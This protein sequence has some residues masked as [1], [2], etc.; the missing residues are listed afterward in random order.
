MTAQQKLFNRFMELYYPQLLCE[1][2]QR[3]MLH[4]AYI[5]V[6]LMRRPLMPTA[7]V[8]RQQLS[9]AYYHHLWKEF[10]YRLRYHLPDPV[11]WLYLE[12]EEQEDAS[13]ANESDTSDTLSDKDLNRLLSFIRKHCSKIESTIFYL[14][15]VQQCTI[16]QI[17]EI[18]GMK[19]KD[20]RE[21]IMH[22]E[23]L[24]K[25]KYYNKQSKNKTL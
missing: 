18:T 22:I 24:L 1:F 11:F 6:F 19:R 2:R 5:D 9:S 7:D 3:D 21:C 10:Q 14:A 16:K 12:D 25:R 13:T 4:S 15:V 17:T 8:F 23:Q 20:V